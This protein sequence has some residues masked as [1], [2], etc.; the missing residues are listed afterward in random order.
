MA[1]EV[2]VSSAIQ[3]KK[4]A[5]VIGA[6]SGIGAALAR[7]LGREGYGLALL[8]RRAEALA[9]VCAQINTETG[10]AWRARPYAHDVTHGDEVPGLFQ[11]ILRDLGRVDLVVYCAAKQAPVALQEY[12]F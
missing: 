12:D 9:E 10:A 3:S 6:S 7:R 1:A 5:I 2:A 8:G 4:A 11:A